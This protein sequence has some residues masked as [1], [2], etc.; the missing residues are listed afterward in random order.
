MDDQG[1]NRKG[2][3]SVNPIKLMGPTSYPRM[4]EHLK[5]LDSLIADVSATHQA[6]VDE[7][8]DSL[9]AKCAQAIET[10]KESRTSWEEL[11]RRAEPNA[12]NN[13]PT[14]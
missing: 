3:G 7:K 13:F 14:T 10:F 1:I 12:R 6:A 8:D 11:M 5:R 2:G 4:V 9:A